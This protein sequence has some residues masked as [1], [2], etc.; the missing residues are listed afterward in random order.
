MEIRDME[1]NK[2]RSRVELCETGNK[3]LTLAAVVAAKTRITFT[4]ADL[5][6]SISAA[7]IRA[8]LCHILGHRR[9]EGQLLAIAIVV[10]NRHEPV[11]R[12]HVLG[13]FAAN[14]RLFQKQSI[15]DY[16]HS[17]LIDK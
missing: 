2:L 4:M 12:L 14:R 17:S 7:S 1:V 8:I 9:V 11:T 13:H 6:L 3:E 15:I 16:K 10:I 5:A